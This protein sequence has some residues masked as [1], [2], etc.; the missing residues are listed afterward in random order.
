MRI[1]DSDFYCLSRC[2]CLGILPQLW[3]D[4]NQIV[5]EIRA[6]KKSIKC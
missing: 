3:M 4:T 2:L 5:D 6:L 1:C